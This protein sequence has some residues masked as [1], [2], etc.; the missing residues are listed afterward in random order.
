MYGIKKPLNIAVLI[1]IMI[2]K[3]DE[4]NSRKQIIRLPCFFEWEDGNTENGGKLH[5]RRRA[6]NT[7]LIN[8]P[9]QT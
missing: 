8:K 1:S 2:K 7:Q 4:G 3:M 9:S 6:S 5:A